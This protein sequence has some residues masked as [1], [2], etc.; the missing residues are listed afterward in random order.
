MDQS[1]IKKLDASDI[2]DAAEKAWCVT[3]QASD[4][5]ILART[6]ETPEKSPATT[7]QSRVLVNQDPRLS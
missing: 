3:L 2:R 4:T 1:A 5:L 6:W 7:R